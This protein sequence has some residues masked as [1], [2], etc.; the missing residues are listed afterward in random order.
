MFT[1]FFVVLFLLLATLSAN[2]SNGECSSWKKANGVSCI[3]A[4]DS[5][6]IYRRSCEKNCWRGRHGRGNWGPKCDRERV[7]HTSNPK[8]YRSTCSKWT[9]VDGVTCRNKRT[10]DWEQKWARACTVGVTES[11]CTDNY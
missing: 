4:G 9:M 3:F 10:G 11:R 5:A 1:K 7:C 8:T 2:A 6:N